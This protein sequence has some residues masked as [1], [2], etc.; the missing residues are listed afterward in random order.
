[1]ANV[2]ALGG[3]FNRP[4]MLGVPQIVKGVLAQI[5]ALPDSEKLRV[6]NEQAAAS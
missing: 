6:I 3:V 4:L 1:M 2:K 5:E